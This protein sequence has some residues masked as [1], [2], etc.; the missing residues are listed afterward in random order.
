LQNKD[1]ENEKAA[2]IYNS[3]LHDP[4]QLCTGQFHQPKRPIAASFKCHC[5]TP[6]WRCFNAG[7]LTGS[8]EYFSRSG[9]RNSHPAAR[10][11]PGVYP[12]SH[13]WTNLSHPGGFLL[14]L[15]PAVLETKRDEPVHAL[16]PKSG[17]LQPG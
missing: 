1:S 6:G 17:F 10:R 15:V 11:D 7:Y 16:P 5:G 3:A 9:S 14:S 2:R 4:G 12:S 8:S 13:V